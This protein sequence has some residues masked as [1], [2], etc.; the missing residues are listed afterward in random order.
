M[1]HLKQFEKYKAS[2][3]LLKIVNEA[4]MQVDDISKVRAVADIPQS[5]LNAVV[6]KCKDTSGKN[7][8]QFYSD[9][10][11]AEEIVKHVYNKYLNIDHISTVPFVGGEDSQPQGQSQVQ[12]DPQAQIQIE[13]Q[14]QIQIE[15]QSEP[16]SEV[17]ESPEEVPTETP[18]DNFEEVTEEETEEETGE[19]NE[20]LPI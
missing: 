10:D 14:A 3:S 12:V 11:I 18:E 20:D 15:P 5:L 17:Q 13:P 7:I 4:V 19:G 8:R 2:N 16:Q 6:K 1:K 9:N